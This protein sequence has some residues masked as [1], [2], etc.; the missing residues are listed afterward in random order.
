M[1]STCLAENSAV[2]THNPM[3]TV[4]E[5]SPCHKEFANGT[6]HA[7]IREAGFTMNSPVFFA[8]KLKYRYI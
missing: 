5:C 1:L 8:K 4:K 7:L 3:P 6:R 2:Q